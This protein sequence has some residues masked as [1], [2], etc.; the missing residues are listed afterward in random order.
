MRHLFLLATLLFSALVLAQG[1]PRVPAHFRNRSVTTDQVYTRDLYVDG[2]ATWAGTVSAPKLEAD[3]LDAG[4]AW[5]GVLGNP[6]GGEV[7]APAGLSVDPGSFV[8]LDEPTCNYRIYKSA[9]QLVLNGAGQPVACIDGFAAQGIIE[10][11]TLQPNSCELVGG[12]SAC[13]LRS[14]TGTVATPDA[15]LRLE[16]AGPDGLVHV[17]R[18]AGIATRA[19]RLVPRA[20]ADIPACIPEL[21][22]VQ[23]TGAYPRPDG[24]TRAVPQTCD[25][26]HWITGSS[27][28]TLTS[29]PKSGSGEYYR[30]RPLA[31][32]AIS[33]VDPSIYETGL[34]GGT[35]EQIV[36]QNGIALCRGGAACTADA[37]RFPMTCTGATIYASPDG[38]SAHDLVVVIDGGCAN[39]PGF[40]STVTIGLYGY[41]DWGYEPPP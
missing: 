10:A 16:A 21:A 23:V 18:D 24:G 34:G 8:C 3:V 40:T 17:V 33:E 26:D 6:D 32:F 27:V 7:Y 11:G 15:G 30:Y 35:F 36:S 20:L 38:G 22:G 31:P 28:F 19:S 29:P 12:A 4:Q 25:G 9:T 5:V 14:A 39:S 13:T 2:G 37:G 1:R 41:P